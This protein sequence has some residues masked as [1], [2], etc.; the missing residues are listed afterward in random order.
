MNTNIPKRCTFITNM[1]ADPNIKA[2]PIHVKI[3]DI[4]HNVL[5]QR[6]SWGK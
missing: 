5:T 4:K 1:W 3:K 6:N 2:D